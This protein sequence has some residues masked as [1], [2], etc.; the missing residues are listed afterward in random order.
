MGTVGVVADEGIPDR[1][2]RR[3]QESR[4]RLLDAALALFV[5]QGE[6]ATT[7][8][9][10]C[11]RADVANRT[12]FNHFA[13]RDELVRA[14]GQ[15]RLSGLDELL[16]DRLAAGNATVPE[17]LVE[18]F[19]ELADHLEASGPHYRALVGRMLRITWSTEPGG[20]TARTGEPH[21]SFLRLIKEGVARG[22]VTDRHDPLT[23][24]DIVVGTLVAVLL[25]WTADAAF[26]LRSALHDAGVALADLLHAPPEPSERARAAPQPDLT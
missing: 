23:L 14:L 18:L 7:I 11:T 21:G 19:D 9:A 8:E 20:S 25:G 26:G 24:A 2:E 1:F 17:L 15:R 13:N 4:S 6:G 5:E 16:A 22:E 12:F 10:I 3:K